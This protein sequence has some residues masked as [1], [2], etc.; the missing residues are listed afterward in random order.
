MILIL[1]LAQLQAVT[2]GQWKIPRATHQRA[3]I[4]LW[5]IYID[6]NH[7]PLMKMVLIVSKT[8]PSPNYASKC[9]TSPIGTTSENLLPHPLP[10]L[11]ASYRAKSRQNPPWIDWPMGDSLPCSIG[12]VEFGV[13]AE[14]MTEGRSRLQHG[15]VTL[16]HILGNGF[17]FSTL[18]LIRWLTSPRR[19]KKYSD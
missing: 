12:G 8:W 17:N 3:M 15:T 9:P 4:S 2:N 14:G 11:V 19:N 6:W 5:F 18:W 10:R 16:N 13:D 7:C 1:F